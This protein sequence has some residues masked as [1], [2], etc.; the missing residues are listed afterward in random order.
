MKTS[1]KEKM[2]RIL[3][4][5]RCPVC[6]E[7]VADTT[8]MICSDCISCVKIIHEPCCQKCGKQL[9]DE[10][11]EYC[12]DC[13]KMPKRFEQG[14]AFAVYSGAMRASLARVKYHNLRQDLDW[15]CQEAAKRYAAWV[16]GQ[17]IQALV[18]VPIHSSRRRGRGYNQA[19]EIAKRLA[20]VWHLPVLKNGLRRV[21]KTVAQKELNF[22]QR[23]HNL[24]Q[25]FA[26][27]S[28]SPEIQ[29]VLLVDDI[30]T[31][32]STMQV[33]TQ[34]LLRGGVRKVCCFSLAAGVD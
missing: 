25:A 34:V 6:Q 7:I 29:N 16:L 8:K 11:K 20:N 18:P 5:R 19:E 23:L 31:T 21:K 32:G 33:C 13:Q 15:F 1:E 14:V 12:T 28:I 22:Q 4:P 24:E 26:F 3:F 10:T 27:G 17:Q 9:K 2:I 30:Y